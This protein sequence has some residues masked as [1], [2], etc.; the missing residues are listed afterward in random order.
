MNHRL[1]NVRDAKFTLFRRD[2]REYNIVKHTM[3][4]NRTEDR[5]A[6]ICP[7]S[8]RENTVSTHSRLSHII[9]Y[10]SVPPFMRHRS[11]VFLMLSQEKMLNS[12]LF[13]FILPQ[14]GNSGHRRRE[15]VL[16]LSVAL[17]REYEERA[18]GYLTCQSGMLSSI[19]SPVT[20]GW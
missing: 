3:W 2:T 11:I 13:F 17:L 15:E 5:D 9:I 7:R 20:R 1:F 8:G 16:K 14:L 12:T 4:L 6:Y 18:A 10:L 19:Q